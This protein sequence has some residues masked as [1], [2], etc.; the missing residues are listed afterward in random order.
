MSAGVCW[1]AVAEPSVQ[2]LAKQAE[3]RATPK[4]VNL[5]KFHDMTFTKC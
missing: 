3:A 1:R 4:R 2:L 5:L